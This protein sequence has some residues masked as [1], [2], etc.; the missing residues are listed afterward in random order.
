MARIAFLLVT[1]RASARCMYL[2]ISYRSQSGD[3]KKYPLSDERIIE[4][5]LRS[6]SMIF[7]ACRSLTPTSLAS[8]RMGSALASPSS[9]KA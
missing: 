7:L 1:I 6:R 2:H 5:F 3:G 8:S 4:P 9:K